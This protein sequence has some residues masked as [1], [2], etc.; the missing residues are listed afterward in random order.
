MYNKLIIEHL[1]V[2]DK[3]RIR[4]RWCWFGVGTGFIKKCNTID[5]KTKSKNYMRLKLYNLFCEILQ[6]TCTVINQVWTGLNSFRVTS[7]IKIWKRLKLKS[8]RK[9]PLRGIQSS[10][11]TSFQLQRGDSLKPQWKAKKKTI[12]SVLWNR[13][14]NFLTSGTGT[15]TIT[16]SKVRTGTIIIYGSGTGTRYN[17]MYLITFL[18]KQLTM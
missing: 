18:W 2:T 1:K 10:E 14:R 17:I 11:C 9:G 5:E 4:S 16:C 7:E 13:N 3:G 8:P 6:E 12:F 15:G